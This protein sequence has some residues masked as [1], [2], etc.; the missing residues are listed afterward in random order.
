MKSHKNFDLKKS[1]FGFFLAGTL[2]S[3]I[4]SS[5]WFMSGSNL[6]AQTS[7]K[8]DLGKPLPEN[9]FIELAK[10]MNPTV[11]NI[12]TAT[13][14]RPRYRGQRPMQPRDPFFDM[15]EDFFGQNQNPQR[16]PARALGTGFII[17]ADGL[18]LTNSHVVDGADV[19]S[20]QLSEKDSAQYRAELIGRDQRTD[21][22][23][24]K[25]KSKK[26][27][28]VAILGSSK[29]LQVGEWVAAFGNPL[30]LGHTTS[31]GIISALGREIDQLNRFP[32]I[33]TDASINPG[34]SGGP[35]VNL[36]GEVIGV[37]A[38]IAAG[39]QGI[40]FAIPIDEAKSIIEVLEKDGVVRRGYLGV[41]MYPYP[42][43]PRA[44]QEME[45]PNT[46]GALIV[47]VL[48]GSPASKSG[49]REYDFVVKFDGKKVNDS[50]EFRRLIADTKAGKTY[51]LELYR[52]GKLTTVP[53]KMED[54]PEDVAESRAKKKPT[55]QGQKAPFELGFTVT[56]LSNELREEFGVPNQI[57]AKP[58]VIDVEFESP[59]AKSGLNVGDIVLDVNRVE[60]SK[61]TE[62]LK[63]LKN[64]QINSMRVLRGNNPLL[65]YI[66]GDE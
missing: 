64:K 21:L 39:A 7:P 12:S 18:I 49:L 35:L 28:P 14:A 15:F 62:V 5:M 51:S 8:L 45:L 63:L 9:I 58:I 36:R 66:G 26:P 56:N 57:K 17:R 54:H 44:A 38:A 3:F 24:I 41:N 37:N 30:G 46:N 6:D 53:V 61:D 55:Y 4:V 59:A 50:N 40:G 48:P 42:I 11:V 10:V 43:N 13:A 19:I 65:I 22:A 32:F 47:G 2:I 23:L 27:L 1:Q 16:Q 29:D 25:I 20:V 60:V 33:Q 52:K 34:N 31:K